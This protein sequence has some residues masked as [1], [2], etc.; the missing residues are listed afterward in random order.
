M[1]QRIL[2]Q[3]ASWPKMAALVRLEVITDFAR[4]TA[5]ALSL[6]P[7]IFTSKS[8]VAPS[9]SAAIFLARVSFTWRRAS[10]KV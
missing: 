1:A 8:A 6:A 9:P 5:W 2:P 4:V 10:R 7:R 3:L